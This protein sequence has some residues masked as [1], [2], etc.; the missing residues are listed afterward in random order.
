MTD[1]EEEAG[2]EGLV[3]VDAERAEEADEERLAHGEPVDRERHEQHEEEQRAHHV[4]R[5]RREVDADR[6]AGG[7]DR[8]HA[9]RLHG[10]R[11]REHADEQTR[12]VAVGVNALVDVADR[13]LEREPAQQR[14]ASRASSGR[15][16]R[17]K[18][19]TREHHASPTHE[20]ELDPE[21][22]ADVVVAEREREADRGEHE[23]RRAA[24]RALEQHR[25]RRRRRPARWRRGGLVDPRRRRR[26][27][28]SAAPGPPCSATKYARTSQREPVVD[29]AR[30]EQPLPAPRHR[31][32][33][34]HHDRER[35]AG[36][37]RSCACARMCSVFA[38]VDLPDDVR[39]AEAGDDERRRR[40]GEIACSRG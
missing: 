35:D 25:A 4:V 12:V 21:V 8:E 5:P 6:L 15:S 40:G 10:E 28:P 27:P 14:D 18:S 19:A 20:G 11:Q 39:G 32:H 33:R 3:G 30:L 34:E 22:A 38:E 16:R 24:E 26:R 9:H 7:P 13:P 37:S 36:T 17:E 1:E 23:R 2:R 29:A 31:P